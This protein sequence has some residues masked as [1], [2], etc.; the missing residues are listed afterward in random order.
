M[1]LLNDVRFYLMVA[2]A[3]L[4]LIVM[5]MCSSAYDTGTDRHAD[6]GVGHSDSQAAEDSEEMAAESTAQEEGEATETQ[7]LVS[8]TETAEEAATQEVATTEEAVT[9]E[10]AVAT[11]ETTES[12]DAAAQETTA[13]TNTEEMTE[14]ETEAVMVEVS[15]FELSPLAD[16]GQ[17]VPDLQSDI[18]NLK[19]DFGRFTGRVD[20][21]T[22]MFEK[23]KEAIG[24]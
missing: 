10:V 12:T 24:Q 22:G 3:I 5:A 19:T 17:A 2:L 21:A 1:G 16:S 14:V 6:A 7:S 11:E 4:F 15:P 9:E 20:G 18:G 8:N 23:V 13:E